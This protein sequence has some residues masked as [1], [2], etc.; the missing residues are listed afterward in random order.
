[1]IE[2]IK[3]TL[4][5]NTTSVVMGSLNT[6]YIGFEVANASN[7]VILFDMN[8]TALY[9]NGNRSFS[10]DIAVQNGVR[11]PMKIKP[12]DVSVMTWPLGEAL[13]QK[14]GEYQLKLTH[15]TKLID[16][17]RIKVRT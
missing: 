2:S 7:E 6:F 8:K 4:V 17:K 11:E 16:E 13:F 12:N 3:L 1:M 9:V 14:A 5:V 15:D 10:W